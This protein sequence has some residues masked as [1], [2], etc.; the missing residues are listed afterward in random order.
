MMPLF[1]C[2]RDLVA[3]YQ[4]VQRGARSEL[5]LMRNCRYALQCN[6]RIVDDCRRIQVRAS[7]GI[8]HLL[9][10]DKRPGASAFQSGA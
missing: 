8:F 9:D 7:A 2:V 10:A 6:A 3:V 5:V 1:L 4:P